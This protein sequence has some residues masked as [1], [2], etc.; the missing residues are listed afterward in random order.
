MEKIDLSKLIEIHDTEINSVELVKEIEEKLFRRQIDLQEI[1]RI[2]K[3]DT[4]P[5]SPLGNRKFDPLETSH[6]FDKGIAP[7]KFTNPVFRYIPGPVRWMISKFIDGYS[8]FDKKVSENRIR[9]FYS[10]V[11]EIVLLRKK[12]NE[13]DRKLSDLIQNYSELK[14]G[15]IYDHSLPVNFDPTRPYDAELSESGRRIVSLIESQKKTLIIH[16]DNDSLSLQII[17]KCP[18]TDI[19]LRDIRQEEFFRQNITSRIKCIEHIHEFEDYSEYQIII[20]A[21]NASRYSGWINER[22][23]FKIFQKASSGSVIFFRF[24]NSAQ[25]FYSP[26]QENFPTRIQQEILINYLHELGFRTVSRHNVSEE[27]SE[28]ITFVKP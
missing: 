24:S 7:P 11:Y 13:M 3:L 28:L 14:A 8:L 2:A 15:V 5:A 27:E 19:L 10:A 25:N 20:L 22:V 17:R 6:L 12:L 16:P 18:D 4:S 23:L 21:F 26:F 1:E 9:A